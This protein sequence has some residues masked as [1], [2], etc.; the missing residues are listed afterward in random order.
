M[1]RIRYNDDDFDDGDLSPELLEQL[2]RFERQYDVRERGRQ[3]TRRMK[4]KAR[5]RLEDFEDARRM[6]NDIDYLR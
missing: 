6:R 5:R 4:L 3:R 1:S 2:E